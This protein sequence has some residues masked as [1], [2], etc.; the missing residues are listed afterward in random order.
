MVYADSS[1]LASLYLPDAKT[2]AANAFLAKQQAPLAFTHFNRLELR[3]LLRNMVARGDA[4]SATVA[5]AFPLIESD[6]NE[7]LL[8]EKALDMGK[9]FKIA[10]QL[11]S[12]HGERHVIRCVDLLHVASAHV[13]GIKVFLTFDLQQSVF[14]TSTG[15]TVKP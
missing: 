9:L 7:G 13:L 14:A 1:F 11:S 15:L 8:I 2:D 5:K 10:E 6:L 3:N 12:R 4:T